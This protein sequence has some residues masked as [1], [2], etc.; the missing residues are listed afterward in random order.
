MCKLGS[1]WLMVEKC[2]LLTAWQQENCK[3][4][5]GQ[6]TVS[7]Q[8]SSIGVFC[9][10]ELKYGRNTQILEFFNVCSTSLI[11][12]VYLKHIAKVLYL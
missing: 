9:S 7:D 10:C 4:F 6:W 11:K 1:N 12:V 5:D 2:G 3:L 8:N